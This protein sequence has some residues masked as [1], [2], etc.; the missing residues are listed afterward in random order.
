M[1][2]TLLNKND[3][4]LKYAPNWLSKS[5]SDHL[6]YELINHV[7][8]DNDKIILPDGS[9]KKCN[10]LVYSYG[11]PSTVYSYSGTTRIGSSWPSFLSKL[12][13]KLETISN[14]CIYSN[15]FILPLCY[16]ENH[17]KFNFA[18][19]NFYN[20]GS[21]GMG[22]H[23]DN[24]PEILKDSVIASLSLGASREFILKSKKN[25]FT[26]INNLE[27][28]SLLLMGGSIQSHYKHGILKNREIKEPRINITFRYIQNKL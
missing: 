5:D 14:D 15:E 24:E 19:L 22:L 26:I 8:W 21:I 23:S 13:P 20:D 25:P 11:D 3:C 17:V 12:L 18:L 16:P 7:E 6:F 4:F 2:K 1:I 28:G 10:R 9:I 27:N